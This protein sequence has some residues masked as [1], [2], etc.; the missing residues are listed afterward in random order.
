MIFLASSSH[1]AWQMVIRAFISVL[2]LS[3]QSLV[4]DRSTNRDAIPH[5][6]RLCQ[7]MYAMGPRPPFLKCV[8]PKIKIMTDGRSVKVT[9][10]KFS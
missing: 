1:C 6:Q 7:M 8:L 3:L 5:V 9:S 4:L 2:P 10:G